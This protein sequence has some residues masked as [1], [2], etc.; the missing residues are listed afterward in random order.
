M[1]YDNVLKRAIPEG[2]GCATLEDYCQMYQPKTLGL[3]ELSANGKYRV[4]GANGLIGY[5]DAYNHSNSEIAIAC[6]GNS[7]GAV[8]RSMP[9]SWITGNAMVMKMRDESIHNEFI[10]QSVPYIN[11]SGAISGSGQPQLTRENLNPIKLIK[12]S[13]EILLRFSKEVEPII[14]LKLKNQDEIDHL[15]KYRDGILPLLMNGQVSIL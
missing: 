12:P 9:F 4:Y 11:V 15:N 3:K 1:A 2:W 6:R 13:I 10:A 14:S 7:C 8:N 5:Y